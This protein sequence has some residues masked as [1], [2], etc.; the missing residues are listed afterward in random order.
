MKFNRVCVLFVGVCLIGAALADVEE[1]DDDVQV[2][3][4]DEDV[5]PEKPKFTPPTVEKNVHFADSFNS[6]DDFKRWTVSQAKKDGAE[7]SISKYDGKWHVE[8]PKDSAIEGDLGLIL[9]SKAKHHAVSS[10]LNKPFKFDGKP[11]IVQYEVRYQNGIDCGGAYVKLLSEDPKLNLK[12]FHDKTPYTIMFGPDKCGLDNKLHFIFRH[13]NPKTG[14]IEEK[15]S[16]KPTASL[17]SYFADKKTHQ[18]SLVVNPDNT[19]EVSVDG[20]VVKEGSLLD[21][22]SPPVNPPKEIEDPNDKKPADWDEREKIPDP[23]AEKPNDWD[24]NE[25]EKI[26]DIEATKPEGWLED[27]NKLTPDPDAEK[28]KDWDDEMDGEWEAPLI[29]NPKC[30][31]APGCGKWEQPMI[32]N[33]KY[34]GKWRAPM[35]DNPN[36]QGVWKP[37]RIPNPNFFEDLEPYKMTPINAVGLELWSMNDEIV[38][39]NFLVTDDKVVAER[40]TEQTFQ[41]KSR[42]EKASSGGRSVVDAISDATRERPWLWALILVVVVLP[43]VLIVAYCCMSKSE[44]WG[45][46]SAMK[47]AA[48]ERPWL[49]AVYVVVL[50]LPLL[51]ISICLC[52]RSGP[53][54]PETLANAKKTDAVSPDDEQK[55]DT[56]SADQEKAGPGG[57]NK[58]ST[59]KSK[60][61]LE[62][63]EDD[64]DDEENE[65]DDAADEEEEEKGSESPR[66]SP[67]KRKSRKD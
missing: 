8:E 11:L 19:F 45:Y 16:K 36:Y 66:R 13:K 27:E 23:D 3:V 50:L 6:K 49:W 34:K 47:G 29:E 67:R 26:V 4:E 1:E 12:Q 22:V 57:D 62:A 35:I 5:K 15:H 31:D 7:E 51:L 42:A 25:P 32:K 41:V 37:R 38:F 24:E 44:A 60:S 9:K 46:F 53:I 65:D 48:D 61:S 63:T 10:N 14:E 39:D 33:P 64:G 2:E 20:T 28:P 58:P 30:Q 59:K 52:P 21:D 55:E 18:Y 40:W 54:K 43:I 17:D 56:E